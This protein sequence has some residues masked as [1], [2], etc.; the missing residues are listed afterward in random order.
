MA[1]QQA[2]PTRAIGLPHLRKPKADVQL[3]RGFRLAG[4]EEH[5]YKEED[6]EREGDA[7]YRPVALA[8]V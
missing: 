6:C 5:H 2:R 4:G 7:V 8:L 1:P 3:R